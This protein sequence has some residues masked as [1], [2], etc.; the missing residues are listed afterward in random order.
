[1]PLILQL[2][3]V[4]AQIAGRLLIYFYRGVQRSRTIVASNALGTIVCLISVYG[5]GRLMGPAGVALAS[6]AGQVAI[7]GY[8]VLDWKRNSRSLLQAHPGRGSSPINASTNVGGNGLAGHLGVK[9]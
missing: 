5:L 6:V 8:C 1:L 3:G 4:M 9:V 2:T 7:V